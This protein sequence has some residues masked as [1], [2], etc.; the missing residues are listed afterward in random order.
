[1]LAAVAGVPLF[2][3]L[4]RPDVPVAVVL[5]GL[6]GIVKTDYLMQTQA[7]SVRAT[8]T[9][10]AE[11]PSAS[12]HPD[13]RRPERP[14]RPGR[15]SA[16]AVVPSVAVAVRGVRLALVCGAHGTGRPSPDRERCDCGPVSTVAVHAPRPGS[17]AV[18]DASYLL[19]TRGSERAPPATRAGGRRSGG[20]G[21]SSEHV[22]ARA[23]FLPCARSISPSSSLLRQPRRFVR[24]RL[25]RALSPSCVRASR[26]HPL[27]S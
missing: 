14:Y 8:P 11:A 18:C 22:H 7:S 3:T 27:T 20:G 5:F 10:S 24:S 1:M 12:P 23:N 17:R 26:C 4:L 19:S 9:P 15:A 16:E 21:I 13:H 2:F 6:S 25:R